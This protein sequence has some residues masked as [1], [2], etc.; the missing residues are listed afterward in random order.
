MRH[1]LVDVSRIL[2]RRMIGRPPS[3]IDRVCNEY[4]RRNGDAARAALCWGPFAALLSRRESRRV[5]QALADPSAPIKWLAFRMILKASLTYWI[6]FNVRGQFLFNTAHAGLESPHYAWLMR[7]R[8]ARLI[9]MVH[10]L[11]PIEFPEY[12]RP[13]ELE[14]HKIRMRSALTLSQGIVANSEHTRRALA[15]FASQTSLPCPPISTALLASA[16]TFDARRAR[17]PIAQTYFVVVGTIEARKNHLLLM[18]LWRKLIDEQGDNAPHL[19]VIGKRGWESENVV[20]MLERC[21]QLKGF[22]EERADCNDE[23]LA[24]YLQHA[25]ALL[26]PSFAEGFGLPL[27]E[28]LSLEVPVIASDLDVF[29]EI[30][31]DVPDYIDPLDG[32]AWLAHIRDYAKPN[33]QMRATQIAR[34]HAFRKTSWDEHFTQVDA[35]LASLDESR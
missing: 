19:V 7:R 32:V 9:V 23:E 8:G 25:Q 11:I 34:M 13:S 14:K 27:V 20:D 15:D 4:A 6:P 31:G 35:L 29:R 22:V 2:F 24:S 3:G 28:A 17:P 21:A 33:S 12:C 26:F 18:Q 30:A 1:V 16:L 5:F 10:D